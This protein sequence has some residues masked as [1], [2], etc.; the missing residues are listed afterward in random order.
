MGGFM[1][2]RYLV[3]L[4]LILGTAPLFREPHL[5]EKSRMLVNGTL[6]RPLDIFDFFLHA[7]PLV[8]LAFKGGQDLGRFL[9][10][11]NG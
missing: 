7:F 9:K 4:A 2:Y 5:V 3:P 1:R 8:L 11:E 10:K 6:S